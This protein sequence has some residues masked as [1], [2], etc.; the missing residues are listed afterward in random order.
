M[1]GR[2]VGGA[3]RV[4]HTRRGV[5]YTHVMPMY[6]IRTDESLDAM[7]QKEW[8]LTNGLGSF[9]SSTIVG[10]NERRYHGVLVAALLPPLGRF[11][12]VNRI[13][14]IVCV[15]GD[16]QH[17]L[18]FSVNQ[19]RDQFHPRGDQYLKLFELDTDFARWHYELPGAKIVKTLTLP[20]RENRA[21]IS[22]AIEPTSAKRVELSLLPMV[23]LRDFHALRHGGHYPYQVSA[24]TQKVRVN[25]GS[26]VAVDVSSDVGTFVERHDTWF[27]QT[28][29]IET[30]R[31]QDDTEDLFTPGT[32]VF[33]TSKPASITLQVVG[34]DPQK[35]DGSITPTTP[36][37]A[38]PDVATPKSSS[39]KSETIQK[40]LRAA[41]DFLVAR[42]APDGTAGTTV[43]AG[44]PWFGDWGRDT[45]ISLPGLLLVPGRFDEARQVLRV[46][47]A[48]VSEGMIP[49]VFDDRTNEPA[50]NTV[51]ASLWFVHAV[52]EYARLSGDKKTFDND[53]RPA[54][55]AILKGYH[56][57]TR[58]RIRM[59]ERDGLITQGDWNTQL[60]WMDA[61]YN[62][63]AFTPRQGK[64]VEINAL[65][66]HALVLMEQKDLAAKV[67]ES[68]RSTFWISPFR[69]LADVVD[70]DR[71]D[72]S[73]R[74]NQ[75]FAVSLSENL[76]SGEQ[77]Q[78]VVEVVRRELLTPHGLRSLAP[79]EPN[80]QGRYTGPQSRRDAAYHNGTVWGWLI[81]PFLEAYLSVNKRSNAAKKQA[82]QWLQ[83]LIDH[84]NQQACIGQISEVFDG[85][86]P[87]R[88]VGACA[89]AW[90]VAEVLRLAVELEM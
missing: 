77:R 35:S 69:G 8:L 40:L 43:L 73:I 20:W 44:Y 67:A 39:G 85:D 90:S 10:C 7:L 88:P 72:K 27:G 78:A 80:Y 21:I 48:Y 31:G 57:G 62:G 63:H 9:A 5:D 61:K 1:R 59:D 2:G 13:G 50:Y 12:T 51:D 60:T 37:V 38:R 89:Q 58:F 19:F 56:Q 49:N 47:A 28:Y 79:G 22:Y 32:F 29:A 84:L 4:F 15:D 71:V 52:F 54:C 82:K 65:W 6:S 14:E 87:H 17:L 16:R 68:F 36:A 74:P 66:H 81:G 24:T 70:D 83:P 45:M 3:A 41:N 23:S 53:L 33:E 25:C 64:A 34:F 76:L 55:E 11:M 86:A 75:I 46:F 42:T 26:S 30:E 18:E